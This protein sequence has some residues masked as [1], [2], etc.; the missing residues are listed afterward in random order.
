MSEHL[1]EIDDG[2]DGKLQPHP[3]HGVEDLAPAVT[4]DRVRIFPGI[5]GL[6]GAPHLSGERESSA[7]MG[8]DRFYSGFR[9]NA[10]GRAHNGYAASEELMTSSPG[11][12]APSVASLIF[13]AKGSDG[14]RWP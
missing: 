13:T 8:K 12:V 11:L 9:W 14:C 2:F 7:A 6:R 10:L 4:G 1:A 5:D 3:V